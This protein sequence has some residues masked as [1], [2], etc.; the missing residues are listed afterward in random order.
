MALKSRK[1]SYTVWALSN[2]GIGYAHQKVI[3]TNPEIASH[4]LINTLVAPIFVGTTMSV[5]DAIVDRKELSTYVRKDPRTGNG[6]R[7]V[8]MDIYRKNVLINSLDIYAGSVIPY[9]AG[10]LVAKII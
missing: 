9:V 4:S 3:D 2:F 10:R 7:I 1:F 6:I 8:G 5:R